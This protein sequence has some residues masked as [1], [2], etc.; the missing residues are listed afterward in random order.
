MIIECFEFSLSKIFFENWN[1]FYMMKNF[2]CNTFIRSL[3]FFCLLG[4]FSFESFSV[5]KREDS[6]YS[7]WDGAKQISTKMKVVGETV[8][9]EKASV[10]DTK[11]DSS[12]NVDTRP[13]VVTVKVQFNPGIRIGQILYLVEKDPDHKA[14]RD[15]NIVGQFEVKSIFHTTFFGLQLR[16]EGYMRLIEDRTMFVAMPQEMENLEEA[17]VKKR[18]GDHYFAIGDKP[19]SIK[20]YKKAISID[21]IYPE[22][23]FA[24]GKLHMQGGEG[25]I[26]AGFEYKI[27]YKNRE[28]FRDQHEKYLF[29]IQYM[30]YLI[31]KH[32]LE[33]KKSLIELDLCY[34]IEKLAGQIVLNDFDLLSLSAEVN[35][36]YYRFLESTPQSP[37]TRSAILIKMQK[38]EELLEKAEKIR[39]E[40]SNLQ[41]LFVLYSYDKLKSVKGKLL[42][43][44]DMKKEGDLLKDAI[45]RHAQS[46][47]VY[48]P[49]S[50]SPDKE[51]LS[52]IELS[53]SF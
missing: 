4:F 12:L 51:T 26:S 17:I 23:H 49:K 50:K 44:Y 33:K 3:V 43:T 9:I 31:F 21:S 5:S 7:F 15:G 2:L 27:A 41:R 25:Y 46:Y 8:S 29:Y 35:F 16:G 11:A 47:F 1:F 22:A 37:E 18:E 30:K 32:K 34:E 39:K 20:A 19:N 36:L 45:Q 53:K 14:L 10:F 28:K 52:A 24:L 48:L 13:D 6:I 38:T 40:D 42:L